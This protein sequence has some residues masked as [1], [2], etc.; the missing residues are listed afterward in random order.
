MPKVEHKTAADAPTSR[1]SCVC[2][3]ARQVSR[4]RHFSALPD[5]GTEPTKIPERCVSV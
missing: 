4:A 2:R 5:R 3:R 1:G